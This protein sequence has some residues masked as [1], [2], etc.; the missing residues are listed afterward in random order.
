MKTMA[1][2]WI[3]HRK[4]VVVLVSETGDQT[5]EIRSNTEKQQSRTDG[6][7]STEPHEANQV[8]AEDR[9]ERKF[10]SQLQHYYD[11]VIAA[12]HDV[13]AVLIFGPGEA[14]C[15]L[16]KR[17]EHTNLSGHRVHIAPVESADKMTNRQIAA[18]VREHFHG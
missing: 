18:K 12:I 4:A 13:E 7:R 1:G 9:Q 3:D 17:L 10:E 8:Q 14:K 5:I 6:V 15:E 16:K 2:L 11:E